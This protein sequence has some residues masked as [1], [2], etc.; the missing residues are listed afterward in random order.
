MSLVWIHEYISWR[1]RVWVAALAGLAVFVWGGWRRNT[2]ALLGSAVYWLFGLG[3][4]WQP[5][6]ESRAVYWLDLTAILV[7]LGMERVVK[8][9]PGRYAL[10]SR[11]Q[12]AVILIGGL[13]LWLFVS[14]WVSQMPGKFYLTACWSGLALIF[15][16]CG[17]LVRE[18]VYR[19]LGL[20]IL[21]C[22]LVRVG[23]VDIW[24]LKELYRILSLIA[25]AV[26]LL[27]LGYIYSRY[28]EKIK[29]WL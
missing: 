21:A 19:W 12:G 15:F 16:L 20:G 2:E 23:F 6:S 4:F 14:R 10:D 29:E 3:L 9:L 25:L 18:R 26:V 7:F 22:A 13:S 24:K 11:V 1:E 28:Q 17:I 27:L 5:W 8:R